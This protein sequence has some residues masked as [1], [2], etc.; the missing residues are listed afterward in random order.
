MI[1]P[2]LSE[3]P[4]QHQQHPPGR[5][6]D[7]LLF[8]SSF[9]ELHDNGD[10]HNQAR[11]HVRMPSTLESISENVERIMEVVGDATTQLQESVVDEVT[12]IADTLMEEL[13]EFDDGNTY[14]EMSLTIN[15]SILPTD[16]GRAVEVANQITNDTTTSPDD[17]MS[18]DEKLVP[19]RAE[20]ETL[21][22]ETPELIM[23]AE[24]V[25][26]AVVATPLSAYLLLAMAVFSLSA[27]GPLLEAQKSVTSSM[28]ICWRQF[29]TSCLLF[30]FA[31]VSV[32]KD[33][34]PRMTSAQ[35]FTFFLTSVCYTIMCVGFVISLEYT[36]VGNA[37]ILCN[38]QSLLLLAGKM[39]VG[40][41]VSFME[42]T[43]ALVAF[44][45]A[46][47]CSIDSSQAAPASAG[48]KTFLGDFIGIVSALGGVGY[49]IFAKQTR[50][51][52]SLY[53][54]MYLNMLM[55]SLFTLS[56]IALVFR[57]PVTFDRNESTGI[58]G[59][60]NMDAD[61]LPLEIAMVIWCNFFGSLGYVR[62]MQFFDN[63][64]IC[65][66]ALVSCTLCHTFFKAARTKVR[67]FE[68][69]ILTCMCSHCLSFF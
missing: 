63:L 29:A 48:G 4:P 55:G 19:A 9:D 47:L 8:S 61:R 13:H 15:L 53:V 50:S 24:S 32:R 17:M 5:E 14:L 18:L 25:V 33:G 37:V 40:H 26:V 59:W 36:A 67:V 46:I 28:K 52:M 31:V 7:P 56:F 27:I 10:D 66:A 3:S 54:F 45:G 68:L 12:E 16:I 44:S 30:P 21:D 42:A 6:T 58:F 49:L 22:L 57:E 69:D 2:D 23:K 65:V 51:H 1:M 62:A 11:T 64:V 60:L 41:P 38:S 39:L 35:W 43:G 34:L 20:M